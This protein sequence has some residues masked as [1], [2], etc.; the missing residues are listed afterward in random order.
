M[1]ARKCLRVI[2]P[3]LIHI[4]DRTI[5]KLGKMEYACKLINREGIVS[6]KFSIY[7]MKKMPNRKSK[8]LSKVLNLLSRSR[9]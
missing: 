5:K 4:L 6:W 7:L 1:I 8:A 9:H 2:I 3:K